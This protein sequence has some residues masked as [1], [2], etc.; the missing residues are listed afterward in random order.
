M[1]DFLLLLLASVWKVES[2]TPRPPD[3]TLLTWAERAFQGG[4]PLAGEPFP[5]RDKSL[6]RSCC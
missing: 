4:N 3:G 2:K 6:L 1:G 5:S